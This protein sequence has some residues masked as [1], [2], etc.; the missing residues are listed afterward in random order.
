ML[1]EVLV[2]QVPVFPARPVESTPPKD[3][4]EMD[5]ALKVYSSITAQIAVDARVAISDIHEASG[6]PQTKAQILEVGH[7][8]DT[9][10]TELLEFGLHEAD[11]VSEVVD[12]EGKKE[13]RKAEEDGIGRTDL[14]VAEG[15][16]GLGNSIPFSKRQVLQEAPEKVK[17]VIDPIEGTTNASLN[18]D[19]SFAIIAGTR[20]GDITKIPEED[21]SAK[22]ADRIVAHKRLKGK[23][24]LSNTAEQNIMATLKE[25][26]I[27]DP[28]EIDVYILG[29][30]RNQAI[31]YG[32]ESLG[33]NVIEIPR[34]DLAPAL[35]A[36][37][38]EDHPILSIGSGGKPEAVIAACAAKALGGAFELMW[39]TGDGNPTDEFPGIMDLDEVV[40]GDPFD[41]FATFASITGVEELDMDAPQSIGNRHLVQTGTITG[42]V[43]GLEKQTLII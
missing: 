42:R 36:L 15:A 23:V 27:T 1:H 20:S 14:R 25:Y 9:R 3:K 5:H 41:C 33:T 6:I 28:H 24:S 39:V 40:S 19:G 22:Y 34:G 4:I 21:S 13:K 31:I 8:L 16:Y 32:Y 29:R 18:K 26:G 35:K 38:T 30:P 10:A 43:P 12:C 37:T 11:F 7:K 17:L 2:E